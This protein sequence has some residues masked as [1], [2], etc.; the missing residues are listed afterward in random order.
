LAKVSK[1]ASYRSTLVIG[2]D[3]TFNWALN[4]LGA[5]RPFAVFPAGTANDLAAHLNL[6]RDVEGALSTIRRGNTVAID[7]IKVNDRCFATAGGGGLPAE[8]ALWVS[9]FRNHSFLGVLAVGS[10]GPLV[11]EL[12]AIGNILFK[13]GIRQELNIKVERS[14]HS[15]V[16]QT[17]ILF[18]PGFLVTNQGT[19]AG[20]LRVAPGALNNDGLFEIFVLSAASRFKL[21]RI[22]LGLRAGT[23]ARRGDF[24]RIQASSAVITCGESSRFFGDG[25]LLAEERVFR[26]RIVEKTLKLICPSNG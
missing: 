10:L 13:R 2:G 22:L 25:E 26:L 12:S 21:L 8:C 14:G 16:P 5:S 6:P 24:Q 23:F 7:L 4:T 20:R 18:S 17:L 1:S 19:L 11:Y 9:S 15:E 3:G